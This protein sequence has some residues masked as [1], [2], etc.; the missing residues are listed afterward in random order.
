MKKTNCQIIPFPKN[1]ENLEEYI[2]ITFDETNF[3]MPLFVNICKHY[4]I[5]CE[6]RKDEEEENIAYG[7]VDCSRK[8]YNDFLFPKFESLAM[9]LTDSFQKV[10]GDL[11]EELPL[12]LQS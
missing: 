9:K 5:P 3:L 12:L 6:I 1:P 2:E 8:F 7:N 4:S 10:Y 11:L